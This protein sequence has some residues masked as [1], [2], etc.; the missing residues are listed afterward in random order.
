MVMFLRCN[1]SF[2]CY[3]VRGDSENTN[4]P[5]PCDAGRNHLCPSH[6]A[7]HDSRTP[8]LLWEVVTSG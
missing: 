1:T 3:V 2:F 6:S 5:L 4:R 7:C 8:L